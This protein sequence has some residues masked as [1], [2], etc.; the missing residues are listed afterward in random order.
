MRK[1]QSIALL[2][3]LPAITA[4]LGVASLGFWLLGIPG[5]PD[6]AYAH[7]WLTGLVSLIA[8]PAIFV[9]ILILRLIALV[10]RLPIDGRYFS[11]A[12]WLAWGIFVL[13]QAAIWT[14]ML[15]S[16]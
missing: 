11:L 12:A 1:L 10:A 13:V 8:Y 3:G 7:P 2:W 4:L 9:L 14:W 6:A 15:S 5:D 16:Q